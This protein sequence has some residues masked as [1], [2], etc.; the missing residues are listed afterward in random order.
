MH[1]IYKTPHKVP[2]FVTFSLFF[3]FLSIKL[4]CRL[5]PFFI[6]LAV[7]VAIRRGGGGEGGYLG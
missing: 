7:E 3:F 5:G 2:S 6:I 4:N 1:H